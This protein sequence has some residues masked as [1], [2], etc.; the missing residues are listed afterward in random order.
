MP[1]DF[2]Q[3]DNN[4]PADGI[5]TEIDPRDTYGSR[6]EVKSREVGSSKPRS[7]I[8]AGQKR[9]RNSDKIFSRQQKD[10]R[11]GNVNMKN[12]N[13]QDKKNEDKEIRSSGLDSLFSSTSDDKNNEKKSKPEVKTEKA[14]A[15]KEATPVQAQ[16][17]RL[18]VIKPIS[19]NSAA[20][21]ISA[22]LKGGCAVVLY[23]KGTNEDTSKRLLDFTFGAASMC[24]AH[25]SLD[26]EKTYVITIGPGLSQRE[27]L[28]CVK[29]G[30]ALKVEN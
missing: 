30:V 14:S 12:V 15:K 28:L 26:A 22:A 20:S 24:G 27:K 17:R 13:A 16:N 2:Y 1:Q 23:L 10:N 25:V 4:L 21:E 6:F 3:E 8:I 7:A 5:G 19:Y 11:G 18:K 29:E 9:L